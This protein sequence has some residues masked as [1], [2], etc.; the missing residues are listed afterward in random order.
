MSQSLIDI[1]PEAW[2]TNDLGLKNIL[3]S[4]EFE[5]LNKQLLELES[6]KLLRPEYHNI[7]KALEYTKPDDIKVVILGQDPYPRPNDAIGLSFAVD[8]TQPVPRSLKNMYIELNDDLNIDN[9]HTHGDLTQWAKQG[10]LLLNTTLTTEVTKSNEHRNSPWG[11]FT[12]KLLMDLD[13][14]STPEKPIIFVLWGQSAKEKGQLLF[15]PNSIKIE[16]VHPSPF[17]A[18]LGFFGS[19]P[20]S[21]INNQLVKTNQKPI[22]W[23]IY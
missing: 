9:T 3:E 16:S 2:A 14:K 8:K 21:K 6:K 1:L 22:D 5:K 7:F 19:K 15:N 10:V 18:R 17:S 20:F 12:S 23:K 4:E 11:S 13:A